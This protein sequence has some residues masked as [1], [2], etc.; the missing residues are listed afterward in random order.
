MIPQPP[1]GQG[2]MNPSGAFTPPQPPPAFPPMP[3]MP[4]FAPWGP[5]PPPPRRRGR[6]LLILLVLLLVGSM[7]VN[8]IQMGSSLGSS[9]TQSSV[10][11]Q[12]DPTQVVAVVP[13][14]GMI[15]DRT[16][17]QFNKFFDQ[18]DKDSRVKAVVIHVETPGG[19]VAASDEMHHRIERFKADHSQVPI[20]VSMGGMA[21]SG[22]YYISAPADYIFASPTTWTGNIGVLAPMYN[23]SDLASKWGVKEQTITAP[24]NGYKN[25]GSPFAPMSETDRAYLQN[26]VNQAYAKFVNVVKTGRGSKLTKPAEQIADGRVLSADDAKALGLVD[27]IGYPD[28]AYAYAAST[29]GLTRPQ[30]VQYRETPSLLSLLGA[31]GSSSLKPV[32][33][34]QI[35]NGINVNVNV[36]LNAALREMATPRVM[37]LWQGQ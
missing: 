15:G 22:G 27:K 3:P 29:A 10:V 20:V 19:S 35:N 30:I 1:P 5:P 31:N 13:V 32:G 16:A 26:L 14:E 37:Y 4:P 36:D 6:G 24:P 11:R 28:E 17:E 33:A 34:A 9:G 25:A 18:I 12:G 8:L 21:T 2:P 7:F 23:V